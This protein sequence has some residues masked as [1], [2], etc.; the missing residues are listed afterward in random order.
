MRRSAQHR[1]LLALFATALVLGLVHHATG[2]DIAS[3]YGGTPAFVEGASGPLNPV[4]TLPVTLIDSIDCSRT[5]HNFRDDGATDV[6]QLTPEKTFRVTR[7][8]MRKQYNV[9]RKAKGR[10]EKPDAYAPYLTPYFAYTLQC[11]GPGP[12][13]LAAEMI[14][15]T[16]RHTMVVP[17]C[18]AG[19]HWYGDMF[20]V[21]SFGFFS[22]AEIPTTGA[23]F[24]MGALIYPPR[25]AKQVEVFVTSGGDL[26]PR[27]PGG[28]PAD[29]SGGAAVSRL[30][31]YRLSEGG[32]GDH[33]NPI[34][35]PEGPRRRIGWF[36]PHANFWHKEFDPEGMPSDEAQA[37]AWM[38]SVADACADHMKHLGM[39]ELQ[40]FVT[41]DEGGKGSKWDFG[42][43]GA[44]KALFEH[45]SAA[46]DRIGAD[47]LPIAAI[48]A[49]PDPERKLMHVRGRRDL[50]IGGGRNPARPDVQND[51]I[52]YMSKVAETF[53]AYPNVDRIAMRGVYFGGGGWHD[54]RTF[55]PTYWGYGD[56]MVNRFAQES[57]I[58]LPQGLSME[59]MRLYLQEHHWQ[60][61]LEWRAEKVRELHLRVRDAIRRVDP[62]LTLM[63][64][65]PGPGG[66]PEGTWN[67]H[68]EQADPRE[69]LLEKGFVPGSYS[70][71][72]NLFI[73]HNYRLN[74]E[75]ALSRAHPHSVGLREW[76]YDPRL[77]GD[78]FSTLEGNAVVA[79]YGKWE[80][81]NHPLVGRGFAACLGPIMSGP[82][83]RYL[84]PL[85]HA[86]RTRNPYSIQLYSWRLASRGR[87]PVLREFIRAYLALPQKEITRIQGSE[88]AAFDRSW[89]GICGDRLVLINDSP[90]WQEI[91]LERDR[92][93]AQSYTDVVAGTTLR[94]PDPQ[95]R[96]HLSMRPFDMRVL[97]PLGSTR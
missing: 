73:Q 18:R 94:K 19:R 6:L 90:A 81:P 32:L 87:A 15:D 17:Y 40:L 74:K 63:L 7:G 97:V 64:V 95:K 49:S 56:W 12:Y 14:N 4:D 8:P 89:A 70:G 85:L 30:W 57:D 21:G 2:A 42:F 46:L 62:G 82:G 53:K 52:S 69:I 71:E 55:G 24:R 38:A 29:N 33:A 78:L 48:P 76:N 28:A 5:D 75:R 58:D 41:G 66:S 11:D 45:L 83:R 88:H 39:N 3:L 27:Y 1:S 9:L 91:R 68:H 77:I 31:L 13:I 54:D 79:R 37:Q 84:H 92:F 61:W 72:Q 51:I 67:Y 43:S 23:V 47:F 93:E 50:G 60:E 80:V 96:F 22:G 26:P 25:D 16:G 86:V 65:G 35:Y 59:D 20:P 36:I 34:T 44:N 10:S